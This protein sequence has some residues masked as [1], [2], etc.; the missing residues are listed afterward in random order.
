MGRNPT[1]P[2]TL[3]IAIILAKRDFFGYKYSS[4]SFYFSYVYGSFILAP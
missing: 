3:F 1:P 4:Y 2:E